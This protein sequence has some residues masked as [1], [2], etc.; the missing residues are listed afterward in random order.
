MNEA[1]QDGREVWSSACFNE[2][3]IE[4]NSGIAA[5][6]G[7]YN[8]DLNQGTPVSQHCGSQVTADKWVIPPHLLP[9]GPPTYPLPYLTSA[10]FSPTGKVKLTQLRLKSLHLFS[11]VVFIS[12]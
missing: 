4:A 8:Q 10:D 7:T 11:L 12:T 5:A 1:N 6:N 9:T 2:H 3:G